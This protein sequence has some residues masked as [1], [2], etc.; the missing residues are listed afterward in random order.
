ME[1]R[2][3][4]PIA[5][6]LLPFLLSGAA[7]LSAQ[8]CWLRQLTVTLGSSAAALNIILIT[9]MGGLAIG[10]RLAE[11]ACKYT[12]R[13]LLLYAA[14]EGGL[15]LYLICSPQIISFT[16]ALFIEFLPTLGH[17]T[18][19]AQ[20]ARLAVTGFILLPPTIAMGMT[21]PVLITATVRQFRQAA[22]YT[23][24][25]YGV[26]T[27]GASLGAIVTGTYLILRFGITMSLRMAAGMNLLAASTAILIVLV[28]CRSTGVIGLQLAAGEPAKSG[29]DVEH[30][31][32]FKYGLLAAGGGFVGMGLEIIFARFL[33]FIIGSSY[34]SHTICITGFLLGIVAGSLLV[35]LVA[36]RVKLRES[37]LPFL[38][39]FAGFSA[40]VSAVLFFKHFPLA[41]QRYLCMEGI[42]GLHPLAIK[43][44]TA[45]ILVVLPAMASGMILPLLVHLLIKK[46][47]NVSFGSSRIFFYN[48]V[49]SVLGVALVGYVLI[50]L[51]GVLNAL[52]L[53]TLLSFLLA[54]Y[55]MTLS[56]RSGITLRK[57][58]FGMAMLGIM[59]TSGLFLMTNNTPLVVHSTVYTMLEDPELVFYREDEGASVSAVYLPQEDKMMLL[60]NGLRAARLSRDTGRRDL[61]LATDVAM[62][63]HADPRTAFFAGLGTG[64]NAGVAGLYPGVEIDAVEIS[65]AAISALPYFDEYTYNVSKND[66]IKVILGDARHFLQATGKRYDLILPDAYISALTG[67][68]YLY[69]VE[70]FQLCARH[71][72]PG[73]RVVMQISLNSSIDQT[74]AAGFLIAFPHV[75]LVR[76]P[77]T[78]SHYLVASNEEIS[79]PTLP[80]AKWHNH[81][82]INRRIQQLGF[83]ESD[84]LNLSRF[85]TK[86]ELIEEFKGVK[87]STDDHP[88]VDYISAYWK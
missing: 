18:L 52:F 58:S 88:I 38:F 7:A 87:A 25:L 21:A 4:F 61:S 28:T 84:N 6:L 60:I 66:R 5:A 8:L 57:L 54:L 78:G 65:D 50:E 16:S 10:S 59:T 83:A 22:S 55:S 71:L 11:R 34:Y 79:F 23:G 67:T 47:R 80:V 3:Q 70:F 42:I 32:V 85:S 14:L 12:S 82:E 63:S 76:S 53:L 49:G 44:V 35:A 46:S 1:R 36:R 41:A 31:R 62:L 19:V 81:A 20:M 68:A 40:A 43:L 51:L 17:E 74:I 33:V 30:T 45:L 26:N 56:S 27:L 73:G 29:R 77:S 48:T 86:A 72:S 24:L 2:T 37:F 64:R 13:Y 39:I 75:E 9:F 15:A 69:N